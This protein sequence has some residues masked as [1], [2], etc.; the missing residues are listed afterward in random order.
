MQIHH[1]VHYLRKIRQRPTYRVLQSVKVCHADH[2]HHSSSFRRRLYAALAF[3]G[4]LP[5]WCHAGRLSTE[6]RTGAAAFAEGDQTM[7]R[8]S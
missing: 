4:F 6:G 3:S 2:R 5:N 7:R 8:Y 1:I